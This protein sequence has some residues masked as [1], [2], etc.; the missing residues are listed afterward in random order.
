MLCR[1]GRC[2]GAGVSGRELLTEHEENVA[3]LL[4]LSVGEPSEQLAFGVALCLGGS[5]ELTCQPG[6]GCRVTLVAPLTSQQKTLA[7]AS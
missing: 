5:F 7:R 2:A 6:E 3:K 4:A 1:V